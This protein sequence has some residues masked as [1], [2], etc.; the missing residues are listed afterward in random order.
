MSLAFRLL[1]SALAGQVL[2]GRLI[3]TGADGEHFEVGDGTGA[4]VAIRFTDRRAP[5][6]L[7][8]D[9]DLRLGE[10]F[11]DGRLVV[12]EGEAFDLLTLILRHGDE[13][14]TSPLAATLERVR[15]RLIGWAQ[16]NG[17]TGARDNA[18]H[19]YDL[20]DDFYAL[21]LDPDWQ[22]SCAFFERPG[23]SLAQAQAAKKR[24]I[25]AKLAL[26]PGQRVLDI[27]CGW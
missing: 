27:G 17:L 20:G 4:V 6:A 12:D 5:W 14:R 1:E 19:H 24:R 7:I 10:L 11:T 15:A 25:A 13:A 9:P 3:V 26:E 18:V 2:T 16:R 21:F 8:V 22:Y 23:Q